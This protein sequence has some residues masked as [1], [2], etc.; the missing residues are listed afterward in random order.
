MARCASASRASNRE[1][2]ALKKFFIS[3]G[4]FEQASGF[5][6]RPVQKCQNRLAF[7]DV[8]IA[9]DISAIA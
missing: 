4:G 5:V 3:L 8:T 1:R 2:A 9:I 6:S 7:G